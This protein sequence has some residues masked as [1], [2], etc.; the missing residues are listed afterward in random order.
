MFWAVGAR[1]ARAPLLR[2]TNLPAAASAAAVSAAEPA[3]GL[4]ARLIDV[5]RPAVDFPAIEAV[6]GGVGFGIDAHLDEGEST[7]M[8]GIAIGDDVDAVDGAVRIEHGTKRIFRRSEIEI[9]YKDVFQVFLFFLN[10][11]SS[12]SGTIG[13]RRVDRTMRT[14]R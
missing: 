5:Q 6:D 4:R 12:E 2:F 14:M 11:Q 8:A 9:T 1:S 13:Q 3:L 7:R 10:L